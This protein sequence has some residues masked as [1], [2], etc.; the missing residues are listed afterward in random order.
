LAA[1]LLEATQAVREHPEAAQTW[2]RL[3]EIYDVNDL[4]DPALFCYAR[5]E[6]LDPEDWKWPYFAALLLESHDPDAAFER[7][8]RAAELE[9][10][11]APLQYRLGFASYLAEEFERAERHFRRALELAPGCTNAALGLARIAIE[12]GE[13]GAALEGLNDLVR[14]AGDEGAVHLHLAQVHRELGRHADAEHEE[15]LTARSPASALPD[16]M[17]LLEDPVREEVERRECVRAK[18]WLDEARQLLLAGRKEEA[19]ASLERALVADPRSVTALVVSARLL[20]EGGR[21]E[22]AAERL[23]RAI[24]FDPAGTE[25]RVELA[26]VHVLSG[27]LGPAIEELEQALAVAP[28]LP[29][30][31]LKLAGLLLQTG[32]AERARTLLE[33]ARQERPDDAETCE[34]LALVLLAQN[35]IGQAARVT[36]ELAATQ[37]A[38]GELASAT[39]SATLALDL[40]VRGLRTPGTPDRAELEALS[41][42]LRAR[43]EGYRSQAVARGH[44]AGE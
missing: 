38:Q 27:Q 10:D 30:A 17:T 6:A 33:Q 35:R 29:G 1:R 32:H 31:K 16:G 13:S 24:A 25:A 44:A 5:A 20:A 37:A 2:G 34:K 14:R 12:R 19:A 15:E 43:L 26:G 4:A 40:A 11:Y 8:S 39:R 18:R 3:G 21:L 28:D 36:S 23:K 22:L 42:E 9:P 41:R 7:L